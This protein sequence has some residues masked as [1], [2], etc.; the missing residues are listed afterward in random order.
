VREVAAVI[1]LALCALERPESYRDLESL[2][3]TLE[4]LRSRVE[5]LGANVT[6]ETELVGVVS[7]FHEPQLRRLA[8]YAEYRQSIV[9]R[10]VAAGRR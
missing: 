8:A 3:A 2:A 7:S 10:S 4:L 9:D 1:S 5:D 6:T